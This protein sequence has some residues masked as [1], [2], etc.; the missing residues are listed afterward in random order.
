V[1]QFKLDNPGDIS[2]A[3][4]RFVLNNPHINV[5][6]L[7]F[8]TFDDVEKYLKLSGS[9]L[10]MLDKK[11]LAGY[12]E[13]MGQLYCRHACG[14]CESQ[15]P[16]NVPVNTIMRYNHY[17]EVNGSEKYAMEK[18]LNLESAKADRCATC[19]GHCESACPYNVPAQSLLAMAH[20]QLTLG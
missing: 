3:A 2:E 11:K 6:N 9:R 19:T 14:I 5:L 10:S 18:Y 4:V 17:F 15:C 7:A 1:K 20:S 13:S 16:H 12:Q 8:K